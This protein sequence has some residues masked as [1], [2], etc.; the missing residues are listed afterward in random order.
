MCM[1]FRNTKI[2]SFT[3]CSPHCIPQCSHKIIQIQ[4]T[5]TNT[6]NKQKTIRSRSVHANQNTRTFLSQQRKRYKNNNKHCIGAQ[7][8]KA[9]QKRTKNDNKPQHNKFFIGFS[10]NSHSLSLFVYSPFNISLLLVLWVMYLPASHISF[11]SKTFSLSVLD[12]P[13]CLFCGNVFTNNTIRVIHWF[14]KCLHTD[15]ERKET[16]N[17][18]RLM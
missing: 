14:Y 18:Y 6:T 3:Q 17:F 1:C 5:Q 11:K 9:E 15:K 2:L 8:Q 7:Q 12:F 13:P 10:T 4:H 16:R